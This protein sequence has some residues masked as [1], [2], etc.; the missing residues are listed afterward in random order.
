MPSG[1]E[2]GIQRIDRVLLAG[3]PFDHD[4]RGRETRHALHD[5]HYLRL[6]ARLKHIDAVT[7]GHL[8]RVEVGKSEMERAEGEHLG[9]VL[10]RG[11]APGEQHEEAG[12]LHVRRT[13][14][15]C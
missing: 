5:V 12:V 11:Q 9:A 1:Q 2:G 14:E 6:V 15:G 7:F 10:L 13:D 3:L 4:H 8:L